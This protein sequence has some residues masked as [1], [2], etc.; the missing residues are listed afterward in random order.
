M[1]GQNPRKVGC[2]A[3]TEG[4]VYL[5]PRARGGG[6]VSDELGVR[7]ATG[8]VRIGYSQVSDLADSGS[9]MIYHPRFSGSGPQNLSVSISG[10][11][12]HPSIPIK[13]NG[14]LCR[15][16]TYFIVYLIIILFI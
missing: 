7:M 14:L 4:F 11:V 3:I 2:N 16:E 13:P 6:A 10:L 5:L 12:F 15:I 1:A 8:Q 9:R